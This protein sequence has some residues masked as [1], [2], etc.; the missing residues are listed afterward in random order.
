MKR[1]S[2]I[3]IMMLIMS[4]CTSTTS[5]N[6]S[7]NTP[8]PNNNTN[9][10]G[11]PTPTREGDSG[12]D[13]TGDPGSGFGFGALLQGDGF[14]ALA[15]GSGINLEFN[16]AGSYGCE[17]GNTYALRPATGEFPQLTII[18][19]TDIT[20]GTFTVGDDNISASL[21]TAENS[22]YAGIIA[23]ILVLENVPASSAERITGNFDVDL[24]NGSNT[25]NV[26]GEFDFVIGEDTVFC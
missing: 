21:A 2:L 18:L 1:L 24:S 6:T 20:S 15:E 9:S 16:D 11:E 26:R 19:P 4:A 8:A 23:G 10:G 25:V 5:T 7:T 13:I 14:A 22:V 3:I 17:N 12:A